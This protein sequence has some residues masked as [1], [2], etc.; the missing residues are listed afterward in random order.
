M[1]ELFAKKIYNARIISIF[2][3][4]RSCLFCKASV[5]IAGVTLGTVRIRHNCSLKFIYFASFWHL[6]LNKSWKIV[7]PTKI[8]IASAAPGYV[9]VKVRR[10]IYFF[11]S[12]SLW[13]WKST[14][15]NGNFKKSTVFNGRINLTQFKS[16]SSQ[17]NAA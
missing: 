9:I 15:R 7:C 16:W 11:T 2:P 13:T 4:S 14:N 3:V 6:L 5:K 8:C 10:T 17:I 1:P 12:K